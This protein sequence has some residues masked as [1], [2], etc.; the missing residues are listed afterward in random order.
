[1][2]FKSLIP[3]SFGLGLCMFLLSY[4]FQLILVLMGVEG[5]HAIAS[6]AG[7]FGGAM[8]FTN[9]FYPYLMSRTFKL[10]AILTLFALSIISF[11]LSAIAMDTLGTIRS[12]IANIT[13]DAKMLFAIIGATVFSFAFQGLLLYFGIHFGNKEGLKMVA[14]KKT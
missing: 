7:S 11:V 13:S 8:V 12:G 6:G 4:A 1:M 10:Y 5:V 14:A 9:Y 3:T 2:N